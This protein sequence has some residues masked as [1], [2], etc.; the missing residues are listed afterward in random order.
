MSQQSTDEIILRAAWKLLW[1]PNTQYYLPNVMKN[2]LNWNNIHIPP[3]EGSSVQDIGP[4]SLFKDSVLGYISLKMNNNKIT[5]LPSITEKGFGY[6]DPTH[7]LTLKIGF[8]QLNFSGHYEVDSGGIV[9][10]AIGAANGLLGASRAM[11]MTGATADNIDLAYQYRDKLTDPS[12]PN[13]NQLVNAYYEQNDTL[14]SIVLAQNAKVNGHDNKSNGFFHNAW[15][16]YTTD[17]KDT[18]FFMNNTSNAAKNPDDTGTGF[19]DDG[20]NHHGFYMETVLTIEAN[21]LIKLGDPRGQELYN[22]IYA[23]ADNSNLNGEAHSYGGKSVNNFMGYVKDGGSKSLHPDMLAASKLRKE[24]IYQKA[25]EEAHAAHEEW[26]ANNRHEEYAP[27]TNRFASTGDISQIT[28]SFT[29]N[30]GLPTLSVTGT[31]AMQGTDL[32]VTVT[33]LSATI[34]LL[35]VTLNPD[36]ASELNARVQNAIANMS[37]MQN[38]MVTKITSGLNSDDVK[39]YLSDRINDAIKKIFG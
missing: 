29:D 12:N 37:F 35:H 34:P 21:S 30:F 1:T 22:S 14:N 33:D 9:G 24:A 5:G 39:K 3:L 4:I 20:Y 26:L 8:G 23:N 10:C 17:G 11:A 28:G 36:H 13:G 27:E 25:Y 31:V 6:D 16:Y 15:I 32:V 7:T 38:L 19:N 2:G 18:A